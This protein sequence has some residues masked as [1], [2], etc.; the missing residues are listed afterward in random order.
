MALPKTL[1][2]DSKLRMPPL[3]GA[4]M[5]ASAPPP[6]MAGAGGAPGGPK[7]PPFGS[8]PA[9]TPNANQGLQVAG[10]MKVGT[11]LKMLTAALNDYGP[12][13]E[14]GQEILKALTS[15]SKLAK[16]GSVSPAGEANQLQKAQL[17]NAQNSSLMA[18]TKQG[19]DQQQAG[20]PGG[21]PPSPPQGTV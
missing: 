10:M 12:T 4:S 1:T 21:A 11:A 2:Q 16:P 15:L 3:P 19:M 7:P 14:G 6:Q 13:S 17:Q 18:A 20:G 9:V 5:P 8:S